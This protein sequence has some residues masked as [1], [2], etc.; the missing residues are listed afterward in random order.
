MAQEAGK[1]AVEE[2]LEE[3][4]VKGAPVA[5]PLERDE[6]NRQ[7]PLQVGVGEPPGSRFGTGNFH[8]EM[9]RLKEIEVGFNEEVVRLRPARRI[10]GEIRECTINSEPRQAGTSLCSAVDSRQWFP[11]FSR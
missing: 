5:R 9:V 3:S 8:V 1:N 6:E 4:E 7:D 10:C 11:V 2:A